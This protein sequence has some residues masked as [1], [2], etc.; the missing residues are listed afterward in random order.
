MGFTAAELAEM[1]R[2]DAEIEATFRLTN[3]DLALGRQID[4]DA[5]LE[6][7][8][9]RARK[10]AERQRRYYEA[11]KDEVAERQRQYREANRGKVAE[12]MRRYYETHKD[13]WAEYMRRY[14]R[15]KRM[16]AEG[17]VNDLQD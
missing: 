6:G 13:E 9:A 3:E 14:R 4:R 10:R 5:V 17:N 12:Y 2:A 15:R 7:M 11:H 8:D 16:E 1:A